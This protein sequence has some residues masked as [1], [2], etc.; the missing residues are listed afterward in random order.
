M[1][2]NGLQTVPSL[3]VISM[4]KKGIVLPYE[5]NRGGKAKEIEK[6]K[7]SQKTKGNIY[8]D[9]VPDAIGTL[10]ICNLDNNYILVDGHSRL[11]GLL[12]RFEDE[13][14][15]E[16]D[17][18]FDLDIKLVEV[19]NKNHLRLIYEKLNNQSAHSSNNKLTN[20]EY[21][22]GYLSQ[23]LLHK[24]N[25]TRKDSFEFDKARLVFCSILAT[26]YESSNLIYD[27]RLTYPIA[28]KVR[29]RVTK[30]Y[31]RMIGQNNPNKI[32]L[33]DEVKE[34]IIEAL[35]YY[36]AAK[37]EF[38]SNIPVDEDGYYEDHDYYKIFETVGC[39]GL[40][41][42]DRFNEKH[43]RLVTN[44]KPETLGKK[45]FDNAK[46]LYE[47]FNR[48]TNGTEENRIETFNF[49]ISTLNKKV[50]KKKK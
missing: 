32:K 21:E 22:L 41:V 14:F 43:L 36:K 37:E 34:K 23:N 7:V 6:V 31:N 29:S 18:N 10:T 9:L 45:I 35:C 1:L 33:S 25:I 42:C 28:Y 11:S 8:E 49:I 16:E 27:E 2:K 20:D 26:V 3:N 13:D 12:K 4:Y 15:P 40:I 44:L 30:L 5:K 46:V 17:F 24:A 38:Y 19:N 50:S 48:S 47:K 39:F